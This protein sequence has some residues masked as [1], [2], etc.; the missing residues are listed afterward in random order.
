QRAAGSVLCWA[1]AASPFRAGRSPGPSSPCVAG[2]AL[3]GR[4]RRPR[5]QQLLRLVENCGRNG[6]PPSLGQTLLTGAGDKDDLVLERVEA[7]V[8]PRDIVV[9]DQ[10]DVLLLEHRALA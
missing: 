5:S 8:R 10:V 7:D 1:R 2:A 3:P 4:S 9:D 6:G